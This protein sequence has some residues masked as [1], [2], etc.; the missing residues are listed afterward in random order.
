MPSMR[1][2]R[3]LTNRE[4]VAQ[5]NSPRANSKLHWPPTSPKDKPGAPYVSTPL[6]SQP[7]IHRLRLQRQ[8]AKHTLM[9]P[10][11]R[12]PTHESLQTLDA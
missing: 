10:P 7:R 9:H 3:A 12:F 6:S 1:I 11:Q 8:H 5:N 4:L 2:D